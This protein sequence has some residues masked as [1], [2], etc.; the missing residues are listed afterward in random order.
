LMAL[1]L[2]TR[3]FDGP[4]LQLGR[5]RIDLTFED[6]VDILTKV[7]IQPDIAAYERHKDESY[8][9]AKNP[10]YL[11]DT[12]FL[13]LY[14]LEDVESI[15]VSE[16]DKPEIVHDLNFPVDPKYH[17]KYSLIIDGGT[18]DHLFDIRQAFVNMAELL[19]DRGRIIQWN[20]TSN[21]S[22]NNTYMS[23]SP[24]LFADYYLGNGFKRCDLYI[25]IPDKNHTQRFNLYEMD[26]NTQILD[27]A[28]VDPR[29]VMVVNVAEKQLGA[30]SDSM[31]V[32]SSWM[33]DPSEGHPSSFSESMGFMSNFRRGHPKIMAAPKKVKWTLIR[34][35][36]AARVKFLRAKLPSAYKFVGRY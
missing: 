26:R 6:T 19:S 4:V 32:Q 13:A 30:T 27:R 10:K 23:F 24:S 2:R 31:P 11:S 20:A 22:E 34:A 16:V 1:E 3:K 35:L 14:G 28:F 36:M 12:E 33:L 9:A 15:D 18:F 21:Y 5:Q 7:G 8:L 29:P 17:G 25:A